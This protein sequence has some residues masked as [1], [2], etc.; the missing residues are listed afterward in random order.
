MRD[1]QDNC[2]N[3]DYHSL[4][5]AEMVVVCLSRHLSWKGGPKSSQGF[6]EDSYRPRHETKETE[7]QATK[8]LDHSSGLP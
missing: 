5:Q 2:V 1:D 4:S 6:E 7:K 3:G 8:L